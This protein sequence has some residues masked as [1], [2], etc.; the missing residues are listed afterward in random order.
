MKRYQ[1]NERH[2]TQEMVSGREPWSEISYNPLQDY[3]YADSE[4]EA[5]EIAR[6]SICED[7]S[8]DTYCEKT[9]SGYKI[10]QST[11]ELLGEFELSVNEVLEEIL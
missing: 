8:C 7:L 10:F 2:F 9:D 1:V 5:F 11:G 6:D 4:S 3:V